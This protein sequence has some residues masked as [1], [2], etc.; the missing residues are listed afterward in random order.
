[1]PHD[2]TVFPRREG[3]PCRAKGTQ[4]GDIEPEM[5]QTLSMPEPT[6]AFVRW[7]LARRTRLARYTVPRAIDRFDL[8]N[9]ARTDG[10]TGLEPG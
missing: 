2:L 9:G 7:K 5:G 3:E 8:Y 4:F 1:M 10:R 6:E